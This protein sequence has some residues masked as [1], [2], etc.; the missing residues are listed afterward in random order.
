MRTNFEDR[1][2]TSIKIFQ[3]QIFSCEFEKQGGGF[4]N[5]LLSL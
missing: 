5:R 3:K 1:L 2:K 4:L